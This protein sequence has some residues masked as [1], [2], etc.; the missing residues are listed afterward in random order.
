MIKVLDKIVEDRIKKV[1]TK[2]RQCLARV[3]ITEGDERIEYQKQA[4]RYIR[5]YTFIT[6]E[7][8]RL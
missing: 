1:D 6:G 2:A 5:M 8:F 7:E 3:Q 4:A